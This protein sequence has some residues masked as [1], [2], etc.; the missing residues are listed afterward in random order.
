MRSL[1]A[2]A[3]GLVAILL[4]AAALPS[5]WLE[6]NVFREAGWVSLA[7]PMAEDPQFRS[8]L[9]AAVVEDLDG[10]LDLPPGFESLA[11]PVIERAADRLAEL[12]GFDQAWEESLA[13]SHRLSLQDRQHPGLAVELAPLADLAARDV[14][15]SLGIE[16]PDAG[17]MVVQTGGP[18][19]NR[20]VAVA[21]QAAAAWPWLA[22]GAVVTAAGAVLAARRRAAAAFWLGLSAVAAG[23]VL[24]LA[25]GNLPVLARQVS[26]DALADAFAGR[27]AELAMQDFQPW[28]AALAVAGLAAAAAGLLLL[29]VGRRTGGPG[30]SR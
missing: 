8:A 29:L 21:G 17:N 9:S 13:A 23:A 28:A 3:L 24:W 16:V 12:D 1:I 14:E 4:A 19:I 7:A 27:L 20:Y 15:Q 26:A 30:P 11:V 22:A 6:R 2:A 10:R 25:A 18:A 5:A